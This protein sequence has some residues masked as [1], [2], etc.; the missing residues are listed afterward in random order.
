MGTPD[1]FTVVDP[2][3]AE[4]FKSGEG[5]PMLNVEMQSKTVFEAF[6]NSYFICSSRLFGRPHTHD[7]WGRHEDPKDQFELVGD[8]LVRKWPYDFY[9]ATAEGYVYC[10]DKFTRPVLALTDN[11]FRGNLAQRYPWCEWKIKFVDGILIE[12]EQVKVQTRQDVIDEVKQ[13]FE[14]VLLS[15]DHPI[16]IKHFWELGFK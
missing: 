10:Q 9:P 4:R 5:Y 6:C 8:V 12:V 16:A 15:D 2:S 1:S 7:K 14:N 13:N 3:D 11:E